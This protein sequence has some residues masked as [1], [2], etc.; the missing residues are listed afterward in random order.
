M[1]D[2]NDQ[3]PPYPGGIPSQQAP[4]Q[5]G[6]QQPTDAQPAAA[7]DNGWYAAAQAR[8]QARAAGDAARP[9]T[10]QPGAPAQ[11]GATAQAAPQAAHAAAQQPLGAT[12]RQ[13][14]VPPVPPQAPG[15]PGAG[16]PEPERPKRRH[17][18]VKAALLGLLG[19]VVGAGALVA[20]LHFAGVI[21]NNT[22]ITTSG[23]GSS[24]SITINPSDDSTT[25]AS[26]VAAKALPSV[27]S[28]NV[29]TSD[30]EGVGSG[31]TLDTDGNILT[32]YH[33]VEGAQTISVSAGG[34][35]YDATVVGTDESSDL[36]VI[37]IDPG[38]NKL[39]PI[40][41]GDSSSLQVGDWV[42]SIGS[43]FGLEQSVSTGIVSSLY[44]STMLQGSSGNTIYTNL[45]QTD[46]AI[47]PGNSGGALV[48]E[49][50]QLVGINSIIESASGSSS[51][52]GFAIPG[53]Y[54]VEVA[55]TI[56][57]GQT[58]KHAYL[59]GSFQTVTAQNARRNNLSV[60]QGAYVAEVTSGSP[61]DQAGIK[62]GDIITAIDDQEI[63][64][65][66]GVVLAVRSHNVGD[67]VQVKLM[68]G[69]QEMTVSVTL[70]SDEALQSQQDDQS[71]SQGSLLER[72]LKQ[73]G[74]GNGSGSDSGSGSTGRG[75]SLGG[76]S[77]D[78]SSTGSASTSAE[79]AA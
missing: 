75:G 37:K 42:M 35:T 72:H 56:I 13:A 31:V 69:S 19:G 70:G 30:A 6:A 17:P 21:G 76:S 66:D 36:A 68:R 64:S 32:N 44:R 12:Q 39:T 67:T 51:G 18:A 60:N 53:N 65:S 5:P 74:Y 57:S 41:V 71:S 4:V 58:V 8:A 20:A 15:V 49:Q 59:G 50:G 47:N 2:S 25:L 1:S 62:Q 78:D 14:Y 27:V 33:V 45:I 26:A 11:P 43:P 3:R 77:Y 24:Q 61:A 63:T 22:T 46:A 29:T 10:A 23:G 48:N 16:A 79:A 34:N 55:K 7:Q 54:A 28:I 40:E 9:N 52:V 73:Y 38:S